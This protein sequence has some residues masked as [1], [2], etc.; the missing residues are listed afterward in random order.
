MRIQILAAA[1]TLFL[2]PSG[3]LHADLKRAMAEPNLE[4]RSGLALENAA[5]ALKAARDAYDRN[6]TDL[7]AK[8]AAEVQES[9]DLAYESLVQ[10]H[11]NPRNS[12]WYKKAEIATR[13]LSRRIE[14]FQDNMSYADRPMLDKVKAD[15][16]KV[17][18]EL[19]MGV[20]EG[21]RKTK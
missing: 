21:K 2:I 20:M 13:N 1:L 7:V 15:V 14:S 4:K 5:A 9:V 11:K 19:L 16:Q 18:D 8:D 3:V 17:H 12:A 10:S 6:D